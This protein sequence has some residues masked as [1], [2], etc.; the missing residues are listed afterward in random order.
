M[1]LLLLLAIVVLMLYRLRRRCSLDSILF[2]IKLVLFLMSLLR[3]LTS[4]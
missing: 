3:Q 4:C 1:L 2:I